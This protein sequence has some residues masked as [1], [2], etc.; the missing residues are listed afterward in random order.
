VNKLEEHKLYT[1][2]T[3]LFFILMGLSFC[4]SY[5]HKKAST[6]SND[7]Q[8]TMEEAF[9]YLKK[10][11]YVDEEDD[12]MMAMDAQALRSSDKMK[13]AVKDFQCTWGIKETGSIDEETV[14]FMSRK[15]C[16]M[17]DSNTRCRKGVKN[18]HN[19]QKRYT[20]Y[21]LKWPDNEVSYRINS[22]TNDL[23]KSDVDA[24]FA[25]AMKV[26]SDASQ[27]KVNELT[28]GNPDI[29]VDFFEG[30]HGD[31]DPFDGPGKVLAHA[32]F[33]GNYDL[34]GD[35]HF[36]DEESFTRKQ[37]TGINFLWVAAHE[38]GH[39]LGLGHSNDNDALMAPFYSGYQENFKLH[40]D[41]IAGIQY[42]YGTPA[43]ETPETSTAT[44]S[45][46][47]V[48]TSTT[49]TTSTTTKKITT[50]QQ[51]TTPRTT[52]SPSSTTQTTPTTTRKITTDQQ[53]TTLST[54]V[55]PSTEIPFE[56]TTSDFEQ[57]EICSDPSIDAVAL[58]H[59]GSTLIFKG[60]YYYTLHSG[61]YTQ[62]LISQDW[63]NAPNDIDAALY[64]KSH[65][66]TLLIKNNYVYVY[67]SRNYLGFM[68]L[69]RW[70]DGLPSKIDSIYFYKSYE[71]IN[72]QWYQNK[73]IFVTVGDKYYKISAY[74]YKMYSDYPRPLSA[75][76][77]NSQSISN[78]PKRIDG[79]YSDKSNR[80][81]FIAN[82]KYFYYNNYY[83]SVQGV[84]ELRDVLS[85][86][87]SKNLNIEKKINNGRLSRSIHSPLEIM[88]EEK[89]TFMIPL[90]DDTFVMPPE[91]EEDNDMTM[92]D[93]NGLIPVEEGDLPIDVDNMVNNKDI[94][95]TME[96]LMN[97]EGRSTEEGNS[98]TMVKSIHSFALIASLIL[99]SIML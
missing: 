38:V 14:K 28:S 23:S 68:T 82:G 36:D 69:D 50:D 33:P 81:F 21:D 91:N 93:D 59:D 55:S 78:L 44:S 86:P 37:N 25:K 72:Y 4:N 92:V 42:L 2:A 98:S 65:D 66:Y 83:D 73:Y 88:G 95:G 80:L 10:F 22:Y 3:I 87:I 39:S 90:G 47:A 26:W 12:S 40:P 71:F 35:V 19:R 7:G 1:M 13:R 89:D 17:P 6:N 85:C 60:K 96:Q 30:D 58:G 74:N 9:K 70:I 18:S 43:E 64:I 46:T 79:A 75:W 29:K 20:T 52:A 63:P 97:S 31:N 49:Q 57:C 45:T 11:D 34:A 32:Y 54:T 8:M 84:G 76:W 56:T 53:T 24:D 67:E 5:P 61:A 99:F 51:T 48:P 62:N 41:D 15:R 16:G 77:E 27:L 94:D